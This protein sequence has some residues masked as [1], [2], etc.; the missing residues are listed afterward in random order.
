M[1]KRPIKSF[2]D[3]FVT[4]TGDV[5]SRAYHFTKNQKCTIRKMKL[6]NNVNGYPTV[7]LH[8]NGFLY[9][10]LVHR[11]VAE[12]FI[13]NPENKPQVNHKNGIKTDNRV[14][15]LEWATRSENEWHKYHVLGYKSPMF[16]VCGKA[17]PRFGRIGNKCPKS[18]IVM[19]IKDGVTIAEFHGC[20]EAERQTKIAFSNINAC[21]RGVRK[22]AGGYQW[23]Y[24]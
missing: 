6:R 17:H 23:K 11:L 9:T 8:K 16:G 19:Q 10:K 24:K 12:A 3:Y 20:L 22:T 15:N 18:K 1:Q 14:E 5:Y 21:C 4:D 7:P 13:P 2:K